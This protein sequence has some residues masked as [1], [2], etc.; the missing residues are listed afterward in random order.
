MQSDDE[1]DTDPLPRRTHKPRVRASA[2]TNLLAALAVVAVLWWGR[3]FL[4]PLTAG[5]M[6]VM[7]VTPLSVTLERWLRSRALAT[8]IT[9]ATVMGALV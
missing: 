9:L 2:A 8:L 6:L 4:I 7:L 5:L 1:D 3:T